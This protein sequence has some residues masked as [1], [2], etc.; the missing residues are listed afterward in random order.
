MREEEE[1]EKEKDCCFSLLQSTLHH[2]TVEEDIDSGKI[3]LI[4]RAPL[5]IHIGI[6]P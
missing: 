1:E 6:D 2:P 3:K 5:G 4:I